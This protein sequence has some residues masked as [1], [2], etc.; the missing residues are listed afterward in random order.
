MLKTENWSELE[1]LILTCTTTKNIL[2]SKLRISLFLLVK[3]QEKARAE[4]C[5]SS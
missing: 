5:F 1:I 4:M 2:Y 3:L